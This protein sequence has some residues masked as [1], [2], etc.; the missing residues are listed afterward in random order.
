ML[1]NF[2]GKR[3]AG[4]TTTIKGQLKF[5][6]GPCIVPDVLGNFDDVPGLHTETT[7]QTILAIEKYKK[8]GEN[9]VIIQKTKEPSLAVDFISTALWEARG[10]TLILDEIDSVNSSEAP[11]FDNLVRYGRN[12][13]IDLITG[14]RRPFE[15][16]RNITANANSIYIFQTHEP[17]DIDY[18]EEIIGPIAYNLPSI[19][20]FSGFYIDYDQNG[21][22]GKFFIDKEG[23]I[24]HSGAANV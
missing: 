20:K 14:C 23:N 6:R 21:F 8:T 22:I 15:I 19:Q 17:R 9:P 7:E 11:C 13:G 5:A 10:G 16:P 2:F 4:K 24:F 18:Y 12:R 3:G 1:N